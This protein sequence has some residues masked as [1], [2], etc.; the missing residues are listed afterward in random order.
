MA[1]CLRSVLSSPTRIRRRRPRRPRFESPEVCRAPGSGSPP[2][3]PQQPPDLH[4]KPLA[5]VSLVVEGG[6]QSLAL[7]PLPD[8]V[9]IIPTPSPTYHSCCSSHPVH[10]AVVRRNNQFLCTCRTPSCARPL[11][12]SLVSPPSHHSLLDTLLVRDSHNL[13]LTNRRFPSPRS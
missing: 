13:H 10:P 8:S 3:R 1:Q 2:P 7:L 4:P 12:R 6:C 11:T 9:A 5:L